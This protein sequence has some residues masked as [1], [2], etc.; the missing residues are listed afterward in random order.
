MTRAAGVLCTRNNLREDLV[1]SWGAHILSWTSVAS[2]FSSSEA[3]NSGKMVINWD[4]HIAF[5]PRACE[6]CRVDQVCQDVAVDWNT[7]VLGRQEKGSITV[8]QEVLLGALVGG[9]VV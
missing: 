4:P 2:V 9:C 8:G 6:P 7:L 3:L 1:V 5:N